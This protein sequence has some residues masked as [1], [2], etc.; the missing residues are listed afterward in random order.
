MGRLLQPLWNSG[1]QAPAPAVAAVALRNHRRPSA[2]PANSGLLRAI[3]AA[4]SPMNIGCGR[5]GRLVSSGWNWPPM[6]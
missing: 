2:V 4:T 3:A 5:T 6:K 1:V